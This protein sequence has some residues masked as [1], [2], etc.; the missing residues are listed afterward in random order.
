MYAW[1]KG[2]LVREVIDQIAQAPISKF[3][4]SYVAKATDLPLDVV[5]EELLKLQKN[6]ILDL[7][8]Q[9]TCENCS[10]E[11]YSLDEIN[12]I[13]EEYSCI[14]CG[15]EDEVLRDRVY[16]VYSITP[17]YK[18]AKKKIQK[19]RNLLQLT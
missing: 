12:A 6:G 13:P 14:Y 16:L 9:I 1:E 4:P 3:Y 2:D 10:R 7:S 5:N 17:M 11:I 18:K 15:H 8:F 19:G